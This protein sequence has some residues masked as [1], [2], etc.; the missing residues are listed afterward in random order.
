MAF[1]FV[2]LEAYSR[3]ADK[4]GRTVEWIIDEAARVPSASVHIESPRPPQIVFGGSLDDLKEEHNASVLAARIQVKN[5]RSRAISKVQKTLFTVVASHPFRVDEVEENRE[6]MAEYEAWE[7]D[8]VQWIFRQFGGQLKVVVRHMDESHMHIHAYVLP[9]GLKANDLHPGL[10]AKRL[11]YAAAVEKGESLK[12]ANK[13][14]DA[15]FKGAMRT[16]QNSYQDEVGAVHGL[17]RV[18]P[19]R[20]RLTKA[21]WHAERVQAQ[22]LKSV[23]HRASLENNS[24]SVPEWNDATVEA[25]AARLSNRFGRLIDQDEL[26]QDIL[27]VTQTACTR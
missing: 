16:W 19:G 23:A 11:A 8:T 6:K 2:H 20:R 24:T 13:M 3:K 26:M 5:G 14:G 7:R 15:A 21:Q 12:A 4:E 17:T 9:S 25:L 18:G 22:A 1:Q 10:C 27:A